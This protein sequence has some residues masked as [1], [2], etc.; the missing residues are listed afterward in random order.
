MSLLLTPEPTQI[1]IQ[2]STNDLQAFMNHPAYIMWHLVTMDKTW[3]YHYTPETKQQTQCVL[4]ARKLVK[5]SRIMHLVSS[6]NLVPSDCHLFLN[7]KMDSWLGKNLGQMNEVLRIFLRFRRIYS[8]KKWQ[9]WIKFEETMSKVGYCWITAIE[10]CNDFP[11][12]CYIIIRIM[13]VWFP[14]WCRSNTEGR[15]ELTFFNM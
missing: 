3:V 10:K 6:P 4:S 14:I 1:R 12:P 5:V 2:T 13:C 8:W 15:R 7:L 11:S 9:T